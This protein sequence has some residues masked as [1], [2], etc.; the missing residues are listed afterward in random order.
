MIS[1]AFT[2]V[3][4]TNVSVSEFYSEPELKAHTD[5]REGYIFLCNSKQIQW[6]QNVGLFIEV[7]VSNSGIK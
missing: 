3:R 2:C 6:A 7:M 1:F 4:M 5:V